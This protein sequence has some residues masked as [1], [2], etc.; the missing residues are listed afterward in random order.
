MSGAWTGVPASPAIVTG[1]LEEALLRPP[2]T[3]A[4]LASDE[5][6]RHRFGEREQIESC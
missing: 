1:R 4:R 3:T 5:V 2:F 6:R